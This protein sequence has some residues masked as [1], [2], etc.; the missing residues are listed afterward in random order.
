MEDEDRGGSEGLGTQ[1]GT[2]AC[3]LR[4]QGQAWQKG[5]VFQ[6]LSGDTSGPG[7]CKPFGT[8]FPK[9]FG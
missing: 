9:G 3:V 4:V 6:E 8:W 2:Q 1:F 7:V 5:W